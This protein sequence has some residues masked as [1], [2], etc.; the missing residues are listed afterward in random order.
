MKQKLLY[1]LFLFLSVFSLHSIQAQ[2]LTAGDIAFVGYHTDANDGF[3]FITLKDI[4]GGEII[5]FT[6]KGWNAT[7]ATWYSNAEDHIVWTAPGGGVSMGTVVSIIETSIDT[8]TV[9]LG[10]AVLDGL[11]TGFSLLGGD[12]ILAYQSS[13]G[14]EPA[15]PTF[16]AGIYGDDNYVHTLGCD[17]TSGWLNCS[18]CTHISGTCATT[19]GDTSGLPAGLTNG[20][21]A[22]ALFPFSGEEDNAKYTGTLTGTVSAVR[23]AINTPS[24]WTTSDDPINIASTEYSG[25]NITP[26]GP[27]CS[28]TASIS[29]QINV[30]CN[31]GATGSLTVAPSNG[32]APYTYL[33]D[34]G[35]A[36]TTA[37]ATGLSAG[38]YEVT[39]TDANGCTA[40]ASTTVTQPTTALSLTPA[41]QTNVACNGGA[42]GAATVNAATGGTAGY[43]YNWTP[44]NPIGDGTTS[45]SGLSAGT[46]TCTV[47][48]ANGCTKSVN[49]T[50]T[51][52]P[53]LN[54]TLASQ[55]NVSCNGGVNGS[56]TVTATGGTV[57]PYTYSWSPSGG[58]AATA[59]GLTAGTYTVTITDANSCTATQ[60]VTITEPTAIT[61]SITSQTNVSCNGGANGSATVTATGGTGTLYLFMVTFRRYGCYS[62]RT[63]RR[64]LYCDYYRCEWMY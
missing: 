48:D 11:S 33:W 3:T 57:Q 50:V 32:T 53:T 24:N 16:I 5:Y 26:D 44:G 14:A 18:T 47:T 45:V 43:T 10:T 61:A 59:T 36:Q 19:S 42:T 4:P 39:V 56:A 1:F 49:F 63:Y 55:T 52:P 40:T 46:W 9:S 17:D 13:S 27:T 8:F 7:G 2:T 60:S 28:M 64:Y 20:V 22:L 6:D 58:T 62:Y 21:N 34:D 31:G 12:S 38:T 29:S 25:I 51:Q 35:A 54:V 15:N 37:T 30:A 41:S 23:A